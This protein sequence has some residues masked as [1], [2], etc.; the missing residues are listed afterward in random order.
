MQKLGAETSHLLGS[1]GNIL[2][3]QT[4]MSDTLEEQFFN[5]RQQFS[6]L[7]EASV[8]LGENIKKA[9]EE[10]M[11]SAQEGIQLILQMLQTTKELQ[12]AQKDISESLQSVIWVEETI[13]RNMTYI[14][15][16]CWYIA[17]SVLCLAVSATRYTAASRAYVVGV[18]VC[19]FLVER[20]VVLL[21]FVPSY[22]ISVGKNLFLFFLVV[23]EIL[24][25]VHYKG[26]EN[27]DH[28]ILT[29]NTELLHR[30]WEKIS[31]EP[32]VIQNNS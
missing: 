30:L 2:E 5:T 6:E 7:S 28:F 25:F 26:T 3:A 17:V 1:V 16:A 4:T 10:Q 24:C 21:S 9:S 19:L 32:A 11:K 20:T 22:V 12:G 31:H 18:L 13:S 23:A 14:K 8:K 29:E 27:R 15:T